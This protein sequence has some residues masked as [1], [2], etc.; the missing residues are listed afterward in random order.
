[1]N[2]SRELTHEKIRLKVRYTPWL[3][4]RLQP[5]N[6]ATDALRQ[7]DEFFMES[8]PVHKTL[9]DIVRRLSEE[10][11]DYAIIGGMA[12]ALHG[13]IRPTEDVDLLMNPQGLERFHTE[14]VGRGYVPIFPGA[15]KHFRNTETGVKVEVIT[16]GEYPGDGKP[17]PVVFPEPRDV[18]I[19]V[20][21][22]RV[23]KLESLIE[24]KLASG[25]TAEHRKLRDLADVQ[26]L[27]EVLHLPLDLSGRLDASVRDEYLRLWSLAQKARE[28]EQET[29]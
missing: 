2:P 19:N 15:R 7:V 9:N 16:T 12:L 1:M 29:T 10:Q 20:G 23:V 8:S 13:F 5:T 11:I 27:I 22:Y 25:L 17:K 14:L 28:D 18:A 4:S 24:L 6:S 26:Q 21:E 3:M